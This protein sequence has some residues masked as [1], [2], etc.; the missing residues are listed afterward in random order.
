LAPRLF[1]KKLVAD[2]LDRVERFPEF[3]PHKH[4]QPVIDGAE[5]NDSEQAASVPTSVDEIQ[6]KW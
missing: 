2:V 1:L 6:L 3:D 4:Y 5:L